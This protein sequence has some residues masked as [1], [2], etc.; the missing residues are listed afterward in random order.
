MFSYR[1]DKVGFFAT[2]VQFL[3]LGTAIVSTVWVLLTGGLA[4]LWAVKLT[5]GIWWVLCIITVLIRVAL[6]RW[7]VIRAARAQQPEA[8]APPPTADRSE[9]T[10]QPRPEVREGPTRLPHSAPRPEVG[11]PLPESS[12][13]V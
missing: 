1:S 6:F 11:A 12:D 13:S 2:I 7:Q 10:G 8:P 5:W 4:H 3:L 9:T